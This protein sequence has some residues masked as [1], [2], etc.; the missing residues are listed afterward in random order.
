MRHCYGLV[1]IASL[2]LGGCAGMRGFRPLSADC[3]AEINHCLAQCP[4]TP[5]SSGSYNGPD[6]AFDSRTDC[7]RQCDAICNK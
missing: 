1:V 7:Q 4:A 5:A 3:R 2:G 6:G